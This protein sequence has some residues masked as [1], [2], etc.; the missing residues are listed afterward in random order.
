MA[1]MKKRGL[2]IAARLETNGV[3]FY[4]KRGKIIMR[5]ATANQPP[6][7]TRG[8]FISRQRVAHNMGLWKRLKSN[9]KPMF[10]DCE[11]TYGRFCTLM[12]KCPVVFLTKE[13]LL[14]GGTLLLPGM[15]VSDG[16]LSNIGYHLCEAN[17]ETILLTNLKVSDNWDGTPNGTD[18]VTAL[19]K[20]GSDFRAGDILRL[21]TITQ[22]IENKVPKIYVEVEDLTLDYGDTNMGFTYAGLHRIDGRLALTGSAFADNATGWAL[23]HISGSKCSS[24]TVATRCTLYEQYTTEEAL[25]IAAASY[26]GL[27][28]QGMITPGRNQ[29]A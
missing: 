19:C 3:T 13:A 1:Q 26:G 27:T 7:R 17:G 18:M 14:N 4:T 2:A 5:S 10:T 21:Y 15:H 25:A 12:C 16:K 9:T 29:K 6:R 22:T 11:N 23:V 8:Q 28:C 20:F 24:Q